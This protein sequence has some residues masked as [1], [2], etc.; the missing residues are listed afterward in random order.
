MADAVVVAVVVVM[1]M[2][3]IDKMVSLS[4]TALLVVLVALTASTTV[5]WSLLLKMTSVVV[6]LQE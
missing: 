5:G 4:N 3:S 6:A 2:G 1:M